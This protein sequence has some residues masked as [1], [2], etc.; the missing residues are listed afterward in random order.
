MSA[1]DGELAGWLRACA[2]RFAGA[3]AELDRIAD[4]VE[5]AWLDECGRE[6]TE[7]AGL[8]RRQLDRDATSCAELAERVARGVR[9]DDA[10]DGPA[11]GP[12]LGSTAARRTD[13]ARGVRIATFGGE[14]DVQGR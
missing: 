5:R 10:A 11:P 4:R 14:Q 6:W 8:V 12:L 3:A 13:A 2:A 1:W 7:R 9:E